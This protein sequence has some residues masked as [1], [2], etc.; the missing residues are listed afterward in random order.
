MKLLLCLVALFFLWGVAESAD[1]QT[2]EGVYVLTKDNFDEFV[3]GESFVVVEFYAPWCGHCK[4]LAPEY[5]KAAQELAKSGVPVKLAKVDATV[6]A[7][8]GTRFGVKGYP[9]LKI[10]RSGEASDYDGPRDHHGIVRWAKGKSGPVST[11]LDTVE[12]ADSFLKEGVVL[13]YGPKEGGKFHEAFKK[14]SSSFQD[15]FR[16]AHTSNKQV[17]EKVFGTVS[18]GEEK[19]IVVHPSKYSSK[20]E[21]SKIVFDASASST[22]DD[23]TAF[24]L[25]K[26]VPLAGEITQDNIKIYRQKGLPIVK[27]YIDTDWE[28]NAKGINYYLNRLRKV[29]K[30]FE[31]KLAFVVASAK[32]FA[33]EV[34]DLGFGST[35][36]PVAIHHLPTQQKFKKDDFKFS[37]DALEQ[38]VKEYLEGKMEPYV[39]SEPIPE[40]TDDDDDDVVKVVAKNF[41]DIV[42]DETK[43]VLLEAY[44]PWCGHCKSLEPKYKQLAKEM[45]K[46]GKT[47]TIAKVDATANDLPPL[48]QAKGYPT[49]FFAAANMKD[50]PLKYGGEREVKDFVSY[51]KKNAF[52]PLT[53]EEP[54]LETEAKKE[55]L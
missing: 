14:V 38:F 51:L 53:D 52:F 42:L 46:Y 32:D 50:K 20:L 12:A 24:L 49:I 8:L 21:D 25:K 16:F 9:T 55:E 48:Y 4:K 35:V 36:A 1:V 44:A 17:G 45:K 26:G 47:L 10:F 5:A 13:Y 28:K 2:E 34:T 29:A 33:S 54:A 37:V 3:K 40:N 11:S 7:D 6:E 30:N 18:E 43:D 31:D 39:K 27:L 22:S 15:L 19:I 23:L 41:K